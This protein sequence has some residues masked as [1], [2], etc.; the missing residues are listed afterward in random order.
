MTDVTGAENSW[1]IG[2]R[3]V[4]LPAGASTLLRKVLEN[5][6]LPD[7]SEAQRAYP[8]NEAEWLANIAEGDNEMAAAVRDLI[9]RSSVS[10]QQDS[11]EGVN[12]YY[13]TPEDVEPQHQNHLFVYIHG[14]AYMAWGGEAGI[15]EAI[16]IALAA[17]LPVL[18]IDYRM[19]PPHPFPAGLEDVITVYT[20]LLSHRSPQSIAL[21]GL[22][23]GGGLA[24]AAIHRLLQLNIAVPGALYAGTPW[25][26]LT[27]TGDSYWIN[28]GIDRILVTYDGGLQE[29]ARIYAGGQD[30]RHPLLSPVYGDFHGFPPTYLVT[31]TRDLFLSNTVRVHT[32]LRAAGVVADLFVF[33]GMA[34]ADYYFEVDTPEAQQAYA[35]LATF[36]R[37]HLHEGTY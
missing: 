5:T 32:K 30:L 16:Y 24:M 13:V 35:E 11:I 17:K 37:Q 25:S 29:Q 26:D 14:G 15:G 1:R 12:V 19:P 4:P 22:S 36:L 2:T 27:K 10:I 33:E 3:N 8:K 34:H 6:P 23:A 7:V 20:Q 18:S 28:E 31:G 9:A 21:G